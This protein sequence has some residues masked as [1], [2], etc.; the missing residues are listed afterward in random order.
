[1][2][3]G[4]IRK[5]HENLHLVKISRYMVHVNNKMHVHVTMLRSYTYIVCNYCLLIP[6]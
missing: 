2:T 4:A 5:I 1:M 6:V 3:H